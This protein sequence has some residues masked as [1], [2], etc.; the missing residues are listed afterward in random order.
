MFALKMFHALNCTFNAWSLQCV[1]SL[2]LH[3]S[4]QFKHVLAIIQG[5]EENLPRL[6]EQPVNA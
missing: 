6:P 3:K 1:S 2:F 5:S 4:V